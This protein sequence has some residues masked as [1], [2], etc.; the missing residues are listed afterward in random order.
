[1]SRRRDLVKGLALSTILIARVADIVP[2]LYYPSLSSH[3]LNMA[4]PTPAYP[5]LLFQILWFVQGIS[6]LIVVI[7]F[8][9]TWANVKGSTELLK[10]FG[11]T[12][13]VT[14]WNAPWFF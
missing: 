12:Q 10:D 3:L 1:M 11:Y 7:F 13:K 14:E 4:K 8:Y 6:S 2:F 5:T 9:L